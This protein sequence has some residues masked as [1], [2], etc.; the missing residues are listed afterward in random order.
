MTTYAYCRISTARQSLARQERNILAEFPDAQII[1]EVFTGRRV[2]GR[3]QWQKLMKI[4]KKGDTIVFDEISR[5]SR[6]SSEGFRLYKQ[7]KE[8][9]I[10]LVFLKQR[11]LDTASFEK[12]AERVK[13]LTVSTKTGDPAAD[14]LVNAVL[15]AVE[16]FSLA[17]LE[18]DIKIA[19]QMSQNEVDLL[20]QRTREGILTAKLNGK[21]VG[22]QK[23][24]RMTVKKKKPI[25]KIIFEKSKDF[26]GTNSDSEVMAILDHSQVAVAKD[27]KG[28]IRMV[29]AH[30]SRNTYYEYK[31]ELSASLKSTSQD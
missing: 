18:E 8:A 12:A 2:E 11:H 28:T 1:E 16:E 23:G 4:V 9:G 25:Q 5:M 13:A 27:K 3:E 7:L 20:S 19:F 29:S 6:S 17:K 21:R 15:T 26:A 24:D 30:V 14:R 22:T 10:Q 31:K